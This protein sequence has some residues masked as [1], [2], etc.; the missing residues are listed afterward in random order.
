MKSS[1]TGGG[2]A[3]RPRIGVFAVFA[4]AIVVVPTSALP[5]VAQDPA[6]AQD[7]FR[8]ALLRNQA[9]PEA[10]L[11]ETVDG[12]H[13]FVLDRTGEPPLLKFQDSF[14]VFALDRVPA[15]RGDEILRTD[16][17]ED[18]VRVTTLGAITLYPVEKP[19]GLPATRLGPAEPLPALVDTRPN[20]ADAIR[21][22]TASAGGVEVDVPVSPAAEV[23]P[24]AVVADAARLTAEGLRAAAG[25][26]EK[27]TVTRIAFVFGADADATVADGALTIQIDPARGYAGRPSSLKIADA[28]RDGD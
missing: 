27:A 26:A 14:E 19:T 21:V 22:L 24:N 11:Y 16:T 15:A 18:L 23:A 28:I 10:A 20:M 25:A 2:G 12:E 7:S 9:G 17:G 5:A 4:A 13:V 8:A 1:R 6:I 3:R